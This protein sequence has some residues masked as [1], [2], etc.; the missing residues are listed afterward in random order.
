MSDADPSGP[1][2]RRVHGASARVRTARAVL[3]GGAAGVAIGLAGA[4][5]ELYGC[6]LAGPL[7][8][9]LALEPRP[10]VLV[11]WRTALAA[12]TAAGFATGALC[13]A[14]A[15]DL[16]TTFAFMPLPVA[17]LVSALLW[18]GQSVPWAGAAVLARALAPALPLWLG[19]PLSI[20]A[21]HTLA[22]MIFPWRLG[23]SQTPWLELV[24][25][26]ELGGLPLLD[27][28][29][30]LFSCGA[31]EAARRWRPTRGT[32][33]LGRELARAWRAPALLS[34]CA[35]GLPLLYGAVR[36]PAVRA[37]RERAPLL[38]VGLVQPFFTVAD[39][40]DTLR[41]ASQHA[42]LLALSREVE[43]AGVDVVTWPE[44]AYAFGWA[45]TRTRD[46]VGDPAVLDE[47]VRGPVVFGAITHDRVGRR[48]S[49]LAVGPDGTVVGR[50]DKVRL[51]PFG[52]YVPLYDFLP[53]A[54]QR[55]FSRGLVP[56]A[57]PTTIAVADATLGVLNCY[58][59]LFPDL[60]RALVLAGADVLSNHTNDAWFL[61]TA[62]PHLHHF[63]A[64]LRA[65][66]TRRD[67]VR[68][69][70]TGVSGL[71]TATG[72]TVGT[73]DAWSRATR[74]LDVRRLSG[75]TPWTLL[76]DVVTPAAAG[77]LLA[78]AVTARRRPAR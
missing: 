37:E 42:L 25:C 34:A 30:A 27:L 49:V 56:G 44:S 32:V 11:P 33:A 47:G 77:V 61:D 50:A 67:L 55:R 16:L 18:L 74:V 59:D 29:V 69:V 15:I 6:A 57:A 35:L 22:P 5:R 8:L 21:A 78:A 24:Q 48:N 3:L 38:R 65:V 51:M 43:A 20:T 31:L 60:S 14:W 23:V 17:V 76:G 1:T 58:E 73:T 54:L 68:T 10:G 12:G 19:L 4:P 75:V 7:L 13:C 53:D 72:E 28:V 40:R 36:L 45:R 39:R 2:E 41:W 9:L 64:R 62:A 46:G 71:V 66:E 52:E 26:V 63:L 70:G